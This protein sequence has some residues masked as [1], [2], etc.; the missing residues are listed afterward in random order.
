MRLDEYPY[1]SLVRLILEYGAA[2]WDPYRKGQIN[3]L[4]RVQNIEAKF[5][6]HRNYS[7]WET[8]TQRRKIARIC[9]LFK[10]YTG[11]R[12]W[13]AIGD[14]LQRQCCLSRVDHDRKIRRLKQKRDIRKYPFVNRTIE[15]WNKLPADALGTLS[16]KSSN[17]RKR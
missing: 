3:A 17:F 13:K 1:T 7:N 5:A 14:R 16:C 10:A 8:L 11:E 9:A 2:R 4:D 12:A 15:V 6:H